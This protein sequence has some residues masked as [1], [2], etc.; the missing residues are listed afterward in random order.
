MILPTPPEMMMLKEDEAFW[1]TV[2]EL[3]L[4]VGTERVSNPWEYRK[5]DFGELD[6]A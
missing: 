1:R 3:V 5:A 6:A 4:A 2:G